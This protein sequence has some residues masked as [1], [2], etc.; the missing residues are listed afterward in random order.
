M[1]FVSDFRDSF[2]VNELTVREFP[3]FILDSYCDND[4]FEVMLCCNGKIDVD[5]YEN[6]I[7]CH[8]HEG[9]LQNT[10]M[11]SV[12]KKRDSLCDGWRVNFR[13]P[14]QYCVYSHY[15]GFYRMKYNEDKWEIGE[16]VDAVKDGMSFE[17]AYEKAKKWIE[18]YG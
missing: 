1:G 14:E 5:T 3:T 15:R 12:L 9:N 6:R 10:I 17:E 2:I 11:F 13:D 7:R 16:F 8:N 18:M 4:A